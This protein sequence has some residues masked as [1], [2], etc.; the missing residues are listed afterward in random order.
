MS[1]EIKF[2]A[3][4]LDIGKWVY[5]YYVAEHG[6]YMD[7]GVPNLNKPVVR[8]YIVDGSGKHDICEESVCQLTGLKDKNGVD[9][10]EGDIVQSS[11]YGAAYGDTAVIKYDDKSMGFTY[12]SDEQDAFIYGAEQGLLRVVGN[13]YGPP[14]N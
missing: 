11:F 3:L 6:Y 10:Y 2:R 9:I 12:E 4:E 13:I 7:N 14:P 5:G 1:R 8:H